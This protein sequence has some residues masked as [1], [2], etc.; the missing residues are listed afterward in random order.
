V[1][2]ALVFGRDITCVTCAAR[3]VA[4]NIEDRTAAGAS[5]SSCAILCSGWDGLAPPLVPS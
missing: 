1:F 4:T 3:V 2:G 5:R